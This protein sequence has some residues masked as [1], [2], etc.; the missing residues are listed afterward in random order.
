[1][2]N[3]SESRMTV[4]LSASGHSVWRV[5]KPSMNPAVMKMGTVPM[6]I[7]SPRRAPCMNDLMR[8]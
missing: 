4:I 8:L 7:F 2:T 5:A 1:M 6:M 3:A